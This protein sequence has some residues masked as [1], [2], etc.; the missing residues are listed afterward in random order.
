MLFNCSPT[1]AS[2]TLASTDETG[3]NWV[4]FLNATWYHSAWELA[5]ISAAVLFEAKSDKTELEVGILNTV[6]SHDGIWVLPVNPG[7]QREMRVREWAGSDGG[8]SPHPNKAEIGQK[9]MLNHPG[10]LLLT[11]SWALTFDRCSCC[12]SEEQ[13][14]HFQEPHL[15][16]IW[17][18]GSCAAKSLSEPF[19]F[20]SIYLTSWQRS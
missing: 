11:W 17:V 4:F 20:Y 19:A 6:R 9:T 1:R 13:R 7:W 18:H 14:A 2:R 15:S 16:N 5:Q 3:Q 8:S 10:C 12:C